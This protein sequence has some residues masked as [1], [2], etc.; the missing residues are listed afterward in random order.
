MLQPAGL[1]VCYNS[2]TDL[3]VILLPIRRVCLERFPKDF[4]STVNRSY[5]LRSKCGWNFN[6]VSRVPC[7]SVLREMIRL[8][9]VDKTAFLMD[10]HFCNRHRTNWK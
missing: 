7:V 2:N 6:F 1:Y 8:R 9:S 5:G 4:F 10:C 3:D